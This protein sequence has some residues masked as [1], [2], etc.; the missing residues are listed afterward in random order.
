ME[1][2]SEIL[3]TIQYIGVKAPNTEKARYFATFLEDLKVGEKVVIDTDYGQTIGVTT[4]LP[5]PRS[6]YQTDDIDKIHPLVRRA[7]E[8]DLRNFALCNKEAL[9][10]LAVAKEEA[11]HL[12][13]GMRFLSANYDLTGN[14][15]VLYFTS[16]NRVD[17]RD[18]LPV[19]KER[20]ECTKLTLLGVPPRDKAQMIGGIG[21]CGLPLCC[22]KFLR[23]FEGISI[24]RAKNQGLSLNTSKI[25]GNCG[26][27]MCC[28]LFEDDYY[29]E[30]HHQ[31]P[32][33]GTQHQI[34]GNSW[35]VASYNVV[36]RTIKLTSDLDTLSLTLEEFFEKTR[37]K[38]VKTLKKQE[39]IPQ[40][41]IATA[42]NKEDD[43]KNV[44]FFARHKKF[45]H[46][47][48]NF[49]KGDN[50]GNETR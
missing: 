4:T 43:E 18:L 50:G 36:S 39:V 5:F 44:S 25:S 30:A 45:F 17:F 41:E 27:L 32:A 8:E 47:K 16:D 1:Q 6:H 19:M 15:L 11:D 24:G 7:E 3:D 26:K 13:L 10:A 12:G 28:L 21:I 29:S 33:V 37:Q 49:K 40:T 9:F 14:N 42:P 22:T 34:D 38:P 20:L 2:T 48:K 23:K 31:F 46:K 35:T